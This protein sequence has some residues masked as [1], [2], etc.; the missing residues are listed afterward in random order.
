ME[1]PTA[2]DRGSESAGGLDFLFQFSPVLSS[3]EENNQNTG[4]VVNTRTPVRGDTKEVRV[5][6]IKPEN[7][8]SF[9]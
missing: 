7:N 3:P 5:T 4:A 1:I 8:M 2:K 9:P 6:F